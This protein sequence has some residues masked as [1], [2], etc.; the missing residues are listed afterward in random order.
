LSNTSRNQNQDL[1]L[2]HKA[3]SLDQNLGSH[4]GVWLDVSP[5]KNHARSEIGV[6]PTLITNHINGSSTLRFDAKTGGN[7]LT[8]LNSTTSPNELSIYVVGKINELS[9]P[10][11]GF[12]L[13]ESGSDWNNGYGL[14]RNADKNELMAYTNSY[15]KYGLT[16][17]FNYGQYMLVSFHH[18][19][20]KLE[21]CLDGQSKGTKTH[22]G[23]ISS[24]TSPLTI[25][26]TGDYLDG[27]IAE[28]IIFNTANNLVKKRMTHN[29]LSSKYDIALNDEDLYF[30]DDKNG[31]DFDHDLCGVGMAEDR[32]TQLY[33]SGKGM[34]NI[35]NCNGI[36][37]DE[38][39]LIASN[40]KS[41]ESIIETNLPKKVGVR[42]SRE[43]R[44][45]T[46][47]LKGDVVEIG[48]VDL[49]FDLSKLQ[50]TNVSD[51]VL[52]IDNNNNGKYSDDEP[53]SAVA[54]L[55]NDRVKFKGILIED[56]TRF[57]LGSLRKSKS[58]LQPILSSI[59]GSIKDSL[60]YLEMK[61]VENS[62]LKTV[63]IQKMDREGFQ[64][65]QTINLRDEAINSDIEFVDR[66]PNSAYSIYQI[67]GV[68]TEGDTVN[69]GRIGLDYESA[70]DEFS[71][72][73]L[74]QQSA[75][76]TKDLERNKKT[77][78][79]KIVVTISFAFILILGL[80]LFFRRKNK[81]NTEERR[82]LLAEIE[83]FKQ[84]GLS[85]LVTAH[86]KSDNFILDKAKIEAGIGGKLNKTD[87][88]ILNIV[89]S[90]PVIT[91]KIIAEKVLLSLEGTSS[92]LRKMYRLFELGDSK[93]KKLA[94]VMEATRISSE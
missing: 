49:E 44:A 70:I 21:L 73:Q 92:S 88:K 27:D 56:G 38:Y 34:V 77:S 69:F 30:Y 87:W 5:N 22:P 32:S 17:S 89:Y 63:L 64:T 7:F 33:C 85:K 47:N 12:L 20:D 43:W 40:T 8:N 57:T 13:K 55:E 74:K 37:E 94:L 52:L 26:W 83:G 78:T 62:N 28:V 23:T 35:S 66:K 29:Y 2:W 3:N 42:L 80:L 18:G 16:A 48:K 9:K 10:W 14:G 46:R 67:L 82:K 68:K 11:A 72:E 81:G 61:L 41:C 59:I 71:R 79:I 90:D 6:G 91:N 24:S 1:I 75:S 86:G 60:V 45:C 31:G 58:T 50:Y 84:K 19:Q 25:G 15:E 54:E 76:L 4:I 65:I 36:D 39:L 93:N 51:F 53:V